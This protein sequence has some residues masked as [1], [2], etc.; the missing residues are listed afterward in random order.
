LGASRLQWWALMWFSQVW[1]GAHYKESSRLDA[2]YAKEGKVSACWCP[3]G[4]H[5][6]SLQAALY[7]FLKP[8]NESS[9]RIVHGYVV[10]RLGQWYKWGALMRRASVW[11]SHK[12]TKTMGGVN[13]CPLLK[14]FTG[15]SKA[16]I[17]KA[18]LLLS[19][20]KL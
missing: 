9:E 6:V 4:A 12:G 7:C 5:A 19:F 3:T 1:G 11:D 13:S 15:L 14:N 18:L 17:L 8:W 16:P 20:L 2:G 10:K